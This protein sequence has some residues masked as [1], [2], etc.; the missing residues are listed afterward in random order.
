MTD[1]LE[2]INEDMNSRPSEVT[3]WRGTMHDARAEIVRLRQMANEIEDRRRHLEDVSCRQQNEIAHLKTR[4]ANLWFALDRAKTGAEYEDDLG[5]IIDRALKGVTLAT[6]TPQSGPM[7]FDK[8]E[9]DKDSAAFKEAEAQ[10]WAA[11]ASL[12]DAAFIARMLYRNGF[13]LIP[14]KSMITQA[15]A[16]DLVDDFAQVCIGY[17]H[18]IQMRGA[19]EEYHEMKKKLVDALSSQERGK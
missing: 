14:V 6:G 18:N 15:Q 10:I 16:Q 3:G 12:E 13:A 4:V 17:D 2:R 5:D 11:G 8:P 7:D 9:P 19:R 1:I